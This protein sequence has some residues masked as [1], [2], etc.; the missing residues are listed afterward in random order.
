M[1]SGITQIHLGA[2]HTSKFL[3]NDIDPYSKKKTIRHLHTTPRCRGLPNCRGR[4]GGSD[5]SPA[6]CR[7]R[8]RAACLTGFPSEL[9]AARRTRISADRMLMRRRQRRRDRPR[10]RALRRDHRDRSIGSELVAN[11][12]VRDEPSRRGAAK[13]GAH[14]TR[15]GRRRGALVAWM[16]GKARC[17]HMEMR[18]R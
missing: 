4:S 6:G 2:T 17:H 14:A 8:A 13:T 7:R 1:F 5:G 3:A 15:R 9:A 16:K 12:P 10:R 18:D 11:G